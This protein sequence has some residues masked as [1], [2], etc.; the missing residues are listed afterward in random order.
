MAGSEYE[1]TSPPGLPT[2]NAPSGRISPTAVWANDRIC[3]W[4]GSYNGSSGSTK[5]TDGACLA[6]DP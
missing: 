2:T 4:G 1:G 6:M 3:V 5:Y